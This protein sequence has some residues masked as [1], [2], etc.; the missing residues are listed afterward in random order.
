MTEMIMKMLLEER[1]KLDAAISALGGSAAGVQT[2]AGKRRGRPPGSKNAAASVPAS[3]P[4]SAHAAFPP[5]PAASDLRAMPSRSSHR[6]SASRKAQSLR[7]KAIWAARRK[8]AQKSAK[9]SAKK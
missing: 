4:S 1:S 9:A 7:M 2:V 3:V 8:D 5:L 6:T